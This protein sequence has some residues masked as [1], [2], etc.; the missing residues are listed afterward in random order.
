M[1]DIGSSPRTD[2]GPFGL[3]TGGFQRSHL[4][5][6]GQPQKHPIKHR[7]SGCEIWGIAENGP[8]W[9]SG[10]DPRFGPFVVGF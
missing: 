6:T 7:N 2:S 3:Q 10:L 5:P 9:G 4:D 1:G 8:F